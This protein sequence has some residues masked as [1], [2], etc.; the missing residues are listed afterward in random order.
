[1]HAKISSNLNV[2]AQT[3]IDVFTR[4]IPATEGQVFK[5]NPSVGC[6]LCV[7]VARK[8]RPVQVAQDMRLYSTPS[9]LKSG[10]HRHPTLDTSLQCT[11]N[12]TM[13]SIT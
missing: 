9:V 5:N 6:F 7:I 12:H 11:P 13:S 3:I 2:M 10:R 1:M 4:T 8:R